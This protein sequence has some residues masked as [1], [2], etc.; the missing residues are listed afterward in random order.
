MIE[1]VYNHLFEFASDSF[2]SENYRGTPLEILD[3]LKPFKYLIE[4]AINLA[5]K[6]RLELGIRYLVLSPDNN[7]LKE[8]YKKV[9]FQS[10]NKDWMYLKVN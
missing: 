10:L 1:T 3:N 8:K 2:V 5:K 9:D 7:D 4:I 6:L